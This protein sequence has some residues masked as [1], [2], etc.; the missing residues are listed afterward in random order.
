[1]GAIAGG[2]MLTLALAAVGYAAWPHIMAPPT[3][4]QTQNLTPSPTP[5]PSPSPT[6]TPT[7]SPNPTPTAKGP[8]SSNTPSQPIVTKPDVPVLATP[9]SATPSGTP[10][11]TSAGAACP[12]GMKPVATKPKVCI[13]QY[14]FPGKGQAPKTSVTLMEAGQLCA[15]RG[16][17]LCLDAEWEAACRGPKAASYPYGGGHDAKK[18]NEDKARGVV[19]TGTFAECLSASD[20]YD[21]SGNAA[22]WVQSGNVRGGAAG[23]G[24]PRCSQLGHEKPEAQNPLV[25]FRCCSDLPE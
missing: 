16:A 5:T 3:P 25:G 11:V 4:T 15:R 19:A 6:P 20:A 9:P 22:E 21:M 14:E 10:S 13:D 17:R 8:D 2:A 24:N 7:P 18:C 23:W 1:M 12:D